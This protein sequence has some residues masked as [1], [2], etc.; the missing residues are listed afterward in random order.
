MPPALLEQMRA[1]EA[2]DQ[3][4][5]ADGTPKTQR[6]RQIPPDTGRFL[7]LLAAASPAGRWVEVGTSAG[8]STLWLSLA[9]A[10]TGRKVTTF[11]V[12]EDKARLARQTFAQAG[13]EEWVDLIVGDARD[14]LGGMRDVAF[15]FLDTEKDVYAPCYELVVPNLVPGGWLVAHNAISHH[16]ELAPLLARALYDPRLDA[17]IVPVGKGELV[18]R[19]V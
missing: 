2:R 12:L 14:Y 7:A 19:K 10:A 9:C 3:Q 8:Y 16:E 15:C 6:L 17:L 1:L 13:V 5:R 4:D 18:C 11:E